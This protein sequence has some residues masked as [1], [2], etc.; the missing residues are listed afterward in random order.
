VSLKKFRLDKNRVLL[1]IMHVRSMQNGIWMVSEFEL[2]KEICEIGKR[3]YN[4]GLLA[5]TDGSISMKL[6]ENEYLCTATGTNK[7]FMPIESICKVDA[8][9]NVIRTNPGFKV[10][11]AMKTHLLIHKERPE[12]NAVIHAYPI[13]ATAYA[14]AGCSLCAPAAL[15]AVN[16]LGCVPF[17]KKGLTGNNE[18]VQKLTELVRYFDAILFGDIGVLT[19]GTNLENAYNKVESVEMYAGLIAKSRELGLCEEGNNTKEKE[20]FCNREKYGFS[21]KHPLSV[22]I[23]NKENKAGCHTCTKQSDRAADDNEILLQEI[24]RKIFEQLNGST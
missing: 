23:R 24:R 17:I 8:E 19:F 5:S 18:D 14:N 16:A 1:L 7:G 11:S 22:C 2:K 10:S 15:E 20:L 21:T 12:M 4:K 9:G 3:L 13:C 6:K